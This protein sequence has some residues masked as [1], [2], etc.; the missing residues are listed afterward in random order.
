MLL[1]FQLLFFFLVPVD[2][3]AAVRMVVV[4]TFV[5]VAVDTQAAVDTVVVDPPVSVATVVVG[6]IVVDNSLVD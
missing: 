6:D 2:T 1:L 3:Q 4:D 5:A